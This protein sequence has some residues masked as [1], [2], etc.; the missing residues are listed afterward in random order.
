MNRAVVFSPEARDD[1]IALY[2]HIA[3]TTGPNTGLG[4]IERIEDRCRG[5][6]AFPQ[7]GTLRDDLRPGLRIL[8]FERR[9]AITFH[10]DDV[11][12]TIDRIFYGGQDVGS[13]FD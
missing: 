2:I 4:Y 8:G 3:S 5:L 6:A 11:K 1:L 13:A 10:H 9:V 7:Q 12:V